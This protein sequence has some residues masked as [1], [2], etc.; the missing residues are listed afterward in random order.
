MISYKKLLELF[1]QSHNPRRKAWSRQ[2][3][4]F[5][6]THNDSQAELARESRRRLGPGVVT[7]VRPAG[8]FWRAEDYHQKYRLRGARKLHDAL[9]A[10]FGSDKAFVDSTAAARIN[11]LLAGYGEK[12]AIDLPP[13]LHA[14]LP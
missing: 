3:E 10:H 7:D 2:Y 11:G 5:V 4:S 8:T 12:S 14:L 13:E 1:W 9:I 6:L